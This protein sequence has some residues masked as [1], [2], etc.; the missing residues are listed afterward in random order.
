[1]HENSVCVVARAFALVVEILVV[2]DEKKSESSEK[3]VAEDGLEP[4][5]LG[6]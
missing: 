6:L 2:R 3:L 4:S 5:T 1:M